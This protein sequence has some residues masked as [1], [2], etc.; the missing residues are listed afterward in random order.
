MALLSVLA[1][2][3]PGVRVA[4]QAP[5]RAAGSSWVEAGGYYQPVTGDFGDWR[6]AYARAVISGLKNVWFLEAKT[7]EAFHDQGSYASLGIVH[8]FSDRIYSQ[9]GI[10]GGTGDYVL[11]DLRVDGS[12]ALKLGRARSL[13][14]AAG[15]TLVDAKAGFTDQAI[16]GSLTW[17]AG[18]SAVAEVGARFNSSN[19]GAVHS[20]R[21]VASLTLGRA[22]Q[23][24]VTFRG[25]AGT[26]GYQLTGTGSTLRRF[27]SQEAGVS[28]RQWFG[29][30]WGAVLGADWYHNPFYTRT[31]LTMGVFRAW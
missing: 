8:T 19:P 5:V 31:G 7:Q 16:F 24:F 14:A 3:H 12:I 25:G 29:T 22:G 17:Y 2:A 23:R 15:V 26:E 11:P 1:V 9:I 30:R 10:G 18:P 13:V 21:G 6:G 4:A 20:G 27:E 28:W